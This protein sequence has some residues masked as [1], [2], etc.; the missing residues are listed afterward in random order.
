MPLFRNIGTILL[1]KQRVD[2]RQGGL[3][4]AYQELFLLQFKKQFSTE[5]TDNVSRPGAV[6]AR[7]AGG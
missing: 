5:V 4:M 1:S 3:D 2:S 7:A 6:R